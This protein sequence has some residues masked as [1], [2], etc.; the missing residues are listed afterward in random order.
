MVDASD[1]A[2]I[3]ESEPT[4]G[5]QSHRFIRLSLAMIVVA[6]FVGV[7]VQIVMSG[8]Q[9]LPSISHYFYTP[10]HNVFVASLVAASLALVVLTGRDVETIF[11]DIAAIFAPLIALVPT[12]ITAVMLPSITGDN[13]VSMG[14]CSTDGNC[15]PTEYL[16]SIYNDVWTYSIIVVIVVILTI[17]LRRKTFWK[18][19]KAEK[20]G[21]RHGRAWLL[22][23]TFAAPFIAIVVVVVL[24]L[25]TFVEPMNTNFPFNPW[26]VLSVHFAATILFFGTFTAVPI[27][28]FLRYRAIKL[29]RAEPEFDELVI[30]PWQANVYQI[31][32]VLMIVNIFALL[33]VLYL[34][35]PGPWVLVSEAL[36][37][38]LFAGFWVVQTIE[39]W[40][41]KNQRSF[42]PTSDHDAPNPRPRP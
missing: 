25:A 30:K 21:N 39:R 28:S 20:P 23:S 34:K 19:W 3:S 10:A 29:K 41:Q 1:S 9:W 12:G 4:T 7:G 22:F 6:L 24:L 31:V 26:L 36:A 35:P 32:P 14:P 17:V 37:L 5:H 2:H 38:T 13:D 40:E 27:A 42:H 16:N 33:V 11:L 15:I 18:L 8:G